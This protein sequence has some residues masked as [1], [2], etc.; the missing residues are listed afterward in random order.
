ML[1]FRKGQ[2]EQDSSNI[3]AIEEENEMTLRMMDKY[4]WWNVRGGSWRLL[5]R[6]TSAPFVKSKM[7]LFTRKKCI[8]NIQSK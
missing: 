6:L 4:G 1:G 5:Y 2:L 3:S 8:D 7:E